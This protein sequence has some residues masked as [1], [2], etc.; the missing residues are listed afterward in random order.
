MKFFGTLFICRVEG[1]KNAKNLF[2]GI[3]LVIYDCFSAE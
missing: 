3:F 1:I 2:R